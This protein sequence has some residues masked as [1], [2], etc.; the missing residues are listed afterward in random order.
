MSEMMQP[1]V[2]V[3]SLLSEYLR[4]G[5]CDCVSSSLC[6]GTGSGCW[7]SRTTGGCGSARTSR[8][9]RSPHPPC[10]R[11]C[12]SWS[13]CPYAPCGKWRETHPRSSDLF[14]HVCVS[15]RSTNWRG[16]IQDLSRPDYSSALRVRRYVTVPAYVTHSAA[17]ILLNKLSALRLLAL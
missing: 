8:R 7:T 13:S 1:F 5:A 11:R 10:S 9:P 12:Y 17:F 6:A 16:A 14:I 3:V 2:H 4:C 15:A